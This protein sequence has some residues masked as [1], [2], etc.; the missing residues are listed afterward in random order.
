MFLWE[1]IAFGPIHSRRLGSS[2]GINV[3]PTDIKICSFDCIYCECGWTLEKDYQ[4]TYFLPAAAI[5]QAIE[6]KLKQCKRDGVQID[7]ITFSGNGEPT[8][9]PEF[10]QIIDK[11][12]IIRNSLYPNAVITCLTNATQL[13]KTDVRTALLKIDNPMLKLDA[14][15]D[16]LLQIINR[17]VIPITLAE[18]VREMQK[19]N[20]KMIIQTLFVKGTIE[21]KTFDNTAESNLAKWLEIIKLVNPQKVVLYSL[22]RETPAQQLTKIYKDDLE[23]IAEKVRNLGINAAVYE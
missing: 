10:L 7:S 2:L 12:I 21:G 23:K 8:L 5:L 4:S 17:P 3:S 19:F 16:E 18:I 6:E 11:L 22:D 13:Q 1:S 9:H 15:T 14:G 20:G